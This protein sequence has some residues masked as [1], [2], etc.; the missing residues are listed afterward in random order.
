MS[1]Q[2]AELRIIAARDEANAVRIALGRAER[3][4]FE[5][6]PEGL[7]PALSEA[8][9]LLDLHLRNLDRELQRIQ[10]ALAAQSGGPI[11]PGF[12]GR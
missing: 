11:R 12:P 6:A 3:A 7:S 1:R 10:G 4:A 2:E 5:A 9:I 8:L